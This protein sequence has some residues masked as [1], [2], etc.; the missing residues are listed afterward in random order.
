MGRGIFLIQTVVLIAC[1]A[2]TVELAN[3]QEDGGAVPKPIGPRVVKTTYA[4]YGGSTDVSTVIT[5]DKKGDDKL[6]KQFLFDRVKASLEQSA[7]VTKV[8]QT[9]G[10]ETKETITWSNAVKHMRKS[11]A[12]V[13]VN[14]STPITLL[15]NLE[16]EYSECPPDAGTY[17][18]GSSAVIKGPYAVY[19]NFASSKN[20]DALMR[21]KQ[22][23]KFSVSTSGDEL[24]LTTGFEIKS[25]HFDESLA[26]LFKIF[27]LPTFIGGASIGPA[28]ESFE[29]TPLTTRQRMLLGVSRMIRQVNE[30][31]LK[32]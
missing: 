27:N 13:T 7:F 23:L 5:G 9:K 6:L 25:H 30:R 19:G 24:K 8:S 28:G 22:E 31:I 17:C 12:F 32:P 21:E 26:Q 4:L 14:A 18:Q 10:V 29:V 1:A 2:L 16:E 20:V 11:S 15:L 3:A